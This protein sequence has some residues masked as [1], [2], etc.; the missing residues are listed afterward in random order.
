MKLPELLLI[1]GRID[2]YISHHAT[3]TP[4]EFCE[5]LH[6]SRS[7]WFR[8]RDILIV[9]WHCPIF[10]SKC[11]RSYCYSEEGHLEVLRFVKE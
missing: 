5:K 2:F 9:N 10:Y 8:I 1:I 4:E 11:C 3:G 6:I 7:A